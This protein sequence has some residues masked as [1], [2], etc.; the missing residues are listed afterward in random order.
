[1][2]MFAGNPY[3]G[4]RAFRREDQDHFHGRDADAAVVLDLW[5]A[6]RL[7]IVSGPV[8]SG[9]TSLL[10]AGVYPVLVEREQEHARKANVLLPGLLSG[11]TTFPFAA[12]PEYNPYAYALLRS[13]SPAEVPTR[14]AGLTVSEF[15]GQ[16][17]QPHDRIIFAAIDQV[18]DIAIDASTGKRRT[19]RREFLTD[20][21][22]ACE[23]IP[24]LHLLLLARTDALDTITASLGSGA[25]YEVKPLSVPN[26]VR[27]IVEPAIASGRAFAPG[28]AQQLV[29]DLRTSHIATPQGDRTIT[30]DRVDPSL[31]QAACHQ[32]WDRLPE[33]CAQVTDWELGEYSD[34]N[35]ALAS[36]CTA[37]ISQV[38]AE[39]ALRVQQLFS[40]LL[41]T[42]IT[43]GSARGAAYE[44]QTST[45]DMP[46]VVARSLVDRHLLGSERRSSVRWYQLLSDRLIDPMRH[47]NVKRASP[48]TADDYLRTANRELA[49]GQAE[50]ACAS[51]MRAL[52]SQPS[53]HMRAHAE[54]LLGN[55]MHEQGEH[56]E[57]LRHYREATALLEAVGDSGASVL[58]QAAAGQTLLSLGD[59]HVHEAVTEF[60]AAVE[61]APNDLVLQTQFA[62]ALWQLGEG[63]AAVAILNGVLGI[64]GSVLEAVR[65]RGEI[66]A[67][68]GDARSARRDLERQSVRDRASA[69][70]AHGL[71][72]AE[73]GDHSE[74][75]KEVNAAV[76]T[77]QQDGR[78]LFY[79]A[80]ALALTG[81]KV[82]AW[83]LA[84]QAVDATDPPLSPSHRDAA[85]KLAGHK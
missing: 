70:A 48:P 79:A 3:P 69:L 25:R 53:L 83:E 2:P 39:S 38:A 40:W 24:Q 9:K 82:T 54:L 59:A 72:L 29:D 19:W 77:A 10:H 65:T 73:L 18:E 55:V 49:R 15:L 78:V 62:I 46:N 27:A 35:A 14:L 1:M 7:T 41:K 5:T 43:D 85:I 44:G 67:D 30:A 64:D 68:L 45:A 63:E 84:Q 58:C 6:N 76:R 33:D 13:W 80:R 36:H 28:T 75:A 50:A 47:V 8:A 61:R 56:A 57:A 11:G 37:I 22:Q 34:V 17:V 51:A 66:L 60:R 26:A 20:L 81:D 16:R 23:A 32:L 52:A 74:A 31:L 21:A 12:I 4:Q 71:A 42:F